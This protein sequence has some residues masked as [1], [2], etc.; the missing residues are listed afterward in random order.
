MP[1]GGGIDRG[2]VN[3][4]SESNWQAADDSS[5]HRADDPSSHVVTTSER[6]RLPSGHN[7]LSS[8]YRAELEQ[9][10]LRYATVGRT[11]RNFARNAARFLRQELHSPKESQQHH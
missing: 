5:C 8:C 9:R 2:T 6:P 11:S 1:L 3:I 10:A 4:S 7:E